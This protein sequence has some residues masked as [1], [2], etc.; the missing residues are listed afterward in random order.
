MPAS[1]SCMALDDSNTRNADATRS[2][3][4]ASKA[5]ADPERAC[6]APTGPG[7]R[8]A[9]GAIAPY[10]GASRAPGGAGASAVFTYRQ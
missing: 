10:P 9:A 5:S 1:R 8:E 7:R 6:V 4:E 3:A 2:G